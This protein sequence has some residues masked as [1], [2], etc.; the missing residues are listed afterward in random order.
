LSRAGVQITG[1]LRAVQAL[2]VVRAETNAL[3]IELTDDGLARLRAAVQLIPV[4][5]ARMESGD[6]V[7]AA[8]VARRAQPLARE[9]DPA[10]ERFLADPRG[11]IRYRGEDGITEDDTSED[12]MEEV[13]GELERLLSDSDSDPALLLTGKLENVTDAGVA[14]RSAAAI[15]I[16]VGLSGVIVCGWLLSVYRRRAESTM[17]EALDR[18][19]RE[20]RTDHLTGLPNRRAVLEE[21]DRRVRA[22]TSFTFALADLNGFK[23]FND[24]FGHPDGD[25]LLRRLGARLDQA[26]AGHG[27]VA[28]LGGDEFCVIADDLAPGTLQEILH[29]ALSETGD[30]FSVTA[31]S[32]LADVPAEAADAAEALNLADNRLYAA[33]AAFYAA[34]DG[35]TVGRRATWPGRGEPRHLDAATRTERRADAACA[36]GRPPEPPLDNTARLL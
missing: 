7:E 14:V 27:Y 4:E 1:Q 22:R 26:W 13:I 16:P 21:L 34:A 28:R 30:G 10:V 25:A 35:R 23:H 18:A 31:E 33:K 20:A 24:T 9:L 32:G 36:P 17:Q 6:S 12:A 29:E 5:L 8:Q 3:E 19:A 11:D 15:L 2:Y